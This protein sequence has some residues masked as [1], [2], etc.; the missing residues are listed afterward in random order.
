MTVTDSNACK[1]FWDITGSQICAAGDTNIIIGNT[2]KSELNS[3]KTSEHLVQY[4]FIRAIVADSCNGDSG[5]G[6]TAG[7][8]D[9]R[10][11]ILGIVSFGEPDCGR[12]FEVSL[13]L[14]F[15]RLNFLNAFLRHT[16]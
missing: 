16:V 9:G 10:E 7:N 11:V 15:D 5:G 3:L 1:S 2:S 13:S 14:S 8:V 12:C 6:L 4:S